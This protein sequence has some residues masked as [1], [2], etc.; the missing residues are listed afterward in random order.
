MI[1]GVLAFPNGSSAGVDSLRPQHLKDL[2]SISNGDA[3]RKLLT[4]LTKFCN[5]LLS[6]NI[7][8]GVTNVLYGATICAL[9]KKG[10]GIRPIAVGCTLRRL[11]SKIACK[12]VREEIG[13][14]LNPHQLGFATKGGTESAIHGTR[15]FVEQNGSSNKVILKIDFEN[16]FNCIERDTL[17]H[18]I[19]K[20]SP[21][22][23]PYL[24]QCYSTP[25][26][27][28]FGN[29]HISSEVGLQQGDPAGPLGF[30]LSIHPIVQ[31]LT[32]ELNVWYLDDGT[33]GGDPNVVLHDFST[34]IKKCRDVGLNVNFSKCELY[35]CGAQNNYIA[36]EFHKISSSIKIVNDLSLLGA[37]ISDNCLS[38]IFDNKFEEVSTLLERV[39]SLKSHIAYYLLK[40]C[41]F[42]PKLNYLLRTSPS[43]K[44]EGKLV[45][46]D[47]EIRSTVE[48]LINTNLN[49]EK[50]TL[51]SLPI[52]YGGLG[53]RKLTDLIFPAFLSSVNSNF[54]LIRTMFNKNVDIANVACYSEGVRNWT[55]RMGENSIPECTATQHG[56]NEILCKS[57]SES[58]VFASQD[59]K[60]LYLASIA[61]E[62]NGWLLALPSRA[63]GTLL[64][65]N[66]FRISVALRIGGVICAHHQCVCGENVTSD[67][68][69]GLS[70]VKSAG[71]HSRH[72]ML[73]DIIRRALVSA[74]IPAVLEPVGMSRDDGK[75]PDG[76]SL[77]PWKSGKCLVWDATCS[78]TVAPSHV[79]L[80][81]RGVALVAE[82]AAT[83]KKA[84]YR[85]VTENHLF[86]PFAVETMGPWCEEARCFIKD[87]GILL[88]S[89]SGDMRSRE[90]LKQRIS[91]AIQK[92]NAA[93][94]M[95]T[96]PS[97]SNMEEIFYI[98]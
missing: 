2:L 23:Y 11:V 19:Q 87:L 61:K 98:L 43:W 54:P 40:H 48:I 82:M 96:I 44:I 63:V 4:S 35:F 72:S 15:S 73:N 18:Q 70:C 56:W 79:E 39:K 12:T 42:I 20:K 26:I 55:D 36:T 97:S 47:S 52:K 1:E 32:S 7:N 34:I 29:E 67:G 90:F 89:V 14:Y 9:N 64:D 50:W 84:K 27:L 78:D 8:P 74:K 66:T 60:A 62:S 22:L 3:A 92:S 37:P 65:N 75:R 6:G 95:G 33:I 31:D 45:Q 68:R 93:C 88:T 51:C 30:S 46:M 58:L 41:L 25:S 71:R 86:V 17:L 21:Q 24:W 69:H 53:I 76:M 94:V 85:N 5:F 10:G 49:E 13:N 80:S 16:A 77:I 91:I 59:E 83:K 57:I 38:S 28:F 81:S